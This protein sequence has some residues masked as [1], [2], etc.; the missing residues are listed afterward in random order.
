MRMIIR[1]EGGKTIGMGH[2]L[3]TMVLANKLKEFFEIIYV[4]KASDIYK[5]GIDFIKSQGFSVIPINEDGFLDCLLN[6]KAECLLTDSY[7]V[8][9]EYFLKTDE[10][11]N[12]TGYIDDLYKCVGPL[13]YLINTSIEAGPKNYEN[14]DI[15]N[16]F[17]GHS[18]ALLRNEFCGVRRHEISKVIKE[19]MITVGGSDINNITQ[20]IIAKVHDSFPDIKQHVVI[21][22]FFDAMFWK[23]FNVPNTY[24]H[25]NPNMAELMQKCDLAISAC[26]NTLYELAACGTPSVGIV[27]AD[28]QKG[29]ANAFKSRG[30]ISLADSVEDLPQAI[31][32][33]DYNVRL[34][35]SKNM[36]QT[37]DGYGSERLTKQIIRL[38][39]EKLGGI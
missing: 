22:P 8:S 17:L 35:Y 31:G 34:Q 7:D 36:Q 19:I 5:D 20:K 16:L 27:V 2:I 4:S 12:V 25:F 33:M 28:N 18:Y 10:R 15:E 39:K 29:I 32:K 30:L 14:R 1:A 21:G 9:D 6:L 38:V 24:I 37:V 23:E 26:G 13:D 3:R 11:F